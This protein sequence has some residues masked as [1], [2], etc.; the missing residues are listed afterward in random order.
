M[1][2]KENHFRRSSVCSRVC[3]FFV[4][5]C[6]RR[7]AFNVEFL[8]IDLMQYKW[9]KFV[10]PRLVFKMNS[11]SYSHLA[12]YIRILRCAS[13]LNLLPSSFARD[14]MIIFH[15]NDKCTK[16]NDINVLLH[17]HTND[18]KKWCVLLMFCRKE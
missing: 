1:T 12:F 11:V 14:N 15:L 5:I 6:S 13:D 10:A 2:S 3:R 7:R 17:N 18:N 9:E 8:R 4:V 16:S